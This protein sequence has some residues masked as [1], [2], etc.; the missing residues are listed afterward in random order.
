MWKECQKE[1]LWKSAQEYPGMKKVRWRAKKEVISRCW[2]WSEENGCYMLRKNA[3][4][5]DA[6]K[7]ILKEAGMLHGPYS[8]WRSKVISPKHF[9]LQHYYFPKYTCSDQH[10][11]FSVVPWWCAFQVESSRNVIAHG[12]AREGK[13]RGKWRMEWVAS[14]LHTTSDHGVS[15]ITTAGA[16]TSSASSQLKWRHRTFLS[17]RPEGSMHLSQRV[18][19]ECMSSAQKS[20]LCERNH[21][22][23]TS[24]TW[25]TFGNPVTNTMP[26][27]RAEKKKVTR[28]RASGLRGECWETFPSKLLQ[29][30]YSL[31]GN[32]GS[33]HHSAPWRVSWW[34]HMPNWYGSACSCLIVI[35]FAKPLIP[36]SWHTFLD[37]MF[38]QMH[39]PS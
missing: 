12:D 22:D 31:S 10:G 17:S 8:Q 20:G 15:S 29:Q 2:K 5:S 14:T 32:V 13:W 37:N 38:R 9:A 11:F 4:D 7:L 34:S 36:C 25:A 27:Q 6:W 35:P 3:R 21:C 33:W 18:I 28:G 23:T 24:R 19:T 39:E 30:D 26:L 16:H 1:E